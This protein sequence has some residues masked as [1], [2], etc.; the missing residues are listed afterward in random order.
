MIS[1]KEY[2][3]MLQNIK[4]IQGYTVQARD[5]AIGS[6]RT[7][8]FADDAW[9]IR[10]LIV[11]TGH[12]LPGKQ[13]LISPFALGEPDKQAQVMPINLTKEQIEN[14]PDID[15]DKPISRQQETLLHGYYN[16]PV[17]WTMTDP[18]AA[19]AVTAQPIAVAAVPPAELL[20]TTDI[21]G[22][23]PHLRSMDEVIGY[24]IQARDG[25]IGHVEDFIIDTTGWHIRYMVVDTR[26]WW[27]GKKVLLLPASI[28]EVDWADSQVHVKL[29]RERVKE[30]PAWDP[31]SPLQRAYETELHTHYNQ[32][33]Y[34]N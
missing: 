34:W 17:Y 30:S 13:V 33:K 22:N 20:H 16:W 1:S 7:F 4:D 23:D 21:Q 28:Q 27:P 10:Y 32:S 19:E 8:Y 29:S 31:N 15:T 11:D 9:R 18:F 24:Y 12:W 6:V 5:G 14:S 2:G 25:Q 3:A 26:N